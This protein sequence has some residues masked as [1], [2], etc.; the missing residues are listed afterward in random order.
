MSHRT[1]ELIT[2]RAEYLVSHEAQ[3]DAL[4]RPGLSNMERYNLF[5]AA[6]GMP[7][8]RTNSVFKE[9]SPAKMVWF[10]GC[11]PKSLFANLPNCACPVIGRLDGVPHSLPRKWHPTADELRVFSRIQIERRF[12]K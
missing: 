9:F 6:V 11:Y 5:A 1:P 12:G 2:E 8:I 4:T 3:I 7:L 10:N